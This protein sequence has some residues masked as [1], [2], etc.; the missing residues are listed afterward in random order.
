MRITITEP[1]STSVG[2]MV[3]KAT[4]RRK[5]MPVVPSSTSRVSVPVARCT[6]KRAESA[7]RWRKMRSMNSATVLCVTRAK[8][9]SR[10]SEKSVAAKRARAYPTSRKTGSARSDSGRLSASTMRL[11]I[12]GTPTEA[13]FASTS[14]AIAASTRPRKAH[15]FTARLHRIVRLVGFSSRASIRRETALG[16]AAARLLDTGYRENSV[17]GKSSRR[18]GQATRG[19]ARLVGLE[20]RIGQGEDGVVDAVGPRAIEHP[21]HDVVALHGLAG[22]EVAQHRGAPQALRVGEPILGELQHLRARRMSLA[23]RDLRIG[24]ERALHRLL[25]A[26]RG[27]D[28]AHVAAEEA[29][30]RSERA[31]EHDLL[32]QVLVDVVGERPVDL[33]L[34][35]RVGDGL[36]ARRARPVPLA[37]EDPLQ[38]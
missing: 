8:I 14:S 25:P 4:P 34:R 15:A 9:T 12:S 29:R 18:R 36:H 32:P 27:H 19:A 17:S 23:L 2:T 38:R 16:G 37:E 33:R 30:A 3:K 7:W 26:R 5:P 21:A 35:E 22:L 13:I 6:W 1:I 10:S 31:Q 28:L 20:V 24:G 11:R